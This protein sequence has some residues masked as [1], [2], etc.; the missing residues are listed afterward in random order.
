[1]FL[2]SSYHFVWNK[3]LLFQVWVSGAKKSLPWDRR[4]TCVN[5]RKETI[6]FYST[7]P[8][9]LGSVKSSLNW[10]MYSPF[11]FISIFYLLFILFF[12]PFQHWVLF[13]ISSCRDRKLP[14]LVTAISVWTNNYSTFDSPG[15]LKTSHY[16]LQQTSFI[17]KAG[18][19][20]LRAVYQ[21]SSNVYWFNPFR[22]MSSTSVLSFS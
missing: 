10:Y 1:M 4:H 6:A 3:T 11:L 18:P 21:V 2:A 22:V 20:P 5:L 17:L 7:H 8:S 14:T 15:I 9:D 19:S 16:F 13:V 12:V